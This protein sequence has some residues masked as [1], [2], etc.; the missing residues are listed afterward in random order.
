[1]FRG[2]LILQGFIEMAQED[3]ATKKS[4]GQPDQG[5]PVTEQEVMNALQKVVLTPRTA[6][7]PKKSA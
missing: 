1:M 7:K 6:V 4:V 5:L 2:T 3:K